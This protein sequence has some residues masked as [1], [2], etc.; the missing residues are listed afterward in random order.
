MTRTLIMFCGQGAQYYQMGRE[1]HHAD[2]IFRDAMDRCETIAADLGGPRI[3]D[4]IFGRP[5]AESQGFDRL[6]ESNAALLAIGFALA[7]RLEAAGIAPDALL[8][9]SLGETIAAVF[10]GALSLEDGFR[11]VLGQA[12]IFARAAPA[13]AMIAVLVEPE[14]LAALPEATRL[15]EIA[16]INAPRH[17]VLSLRADDAAVVEA[18]LE[19]AG[20]TYARLPI[21]FP[22]HAS[23]IAPVEPDMIRLASGCRFAP[24]RWPI[25]SATTGGVAEP[26]D[27]AHLW[28]VMR[29][30]LR[31]RE[32]I[33]ALAREGDWLLLEAGPSGTLASFVRQIGAPGVAAFPAIDQFGN[34]SATLARLLAAAR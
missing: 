11:L 8:G 14:R 33:E 3:A 29:Q 16:A 9:Y 23:A 22:F 26:F 5:M 1:L 27:G 4:V 34:N 18:A 10:A 17:C 28:R 7:T 30:P 19:R 20:L 21:R 12:D 24:P 6:A 2:P 13:G 31:F 15:C 32:T 25:V